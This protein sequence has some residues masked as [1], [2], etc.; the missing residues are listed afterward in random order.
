MTMRYYEL[1]IYMNYLSIIKS[2][3]I[4][5]KLTVQTPAIRSNNKKQCK[6]NI[7]QHVAGIN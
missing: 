4:V 7:L 1:L 3:L 2:L 6:H 5:S